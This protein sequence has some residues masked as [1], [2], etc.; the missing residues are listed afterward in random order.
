MNVQRGTLLPFIHMKGMKSIQE[1]DEELEEYNAEEDHTPFCGV[2]RRIL[3][4]EPLKDFQQRENIFYTR[5]KVM[6]KSCDVIVDGDHA[7]K[8]RLLNL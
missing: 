2:V 6:D 8:W 5:C 1:E 3:H 4:S 7:R